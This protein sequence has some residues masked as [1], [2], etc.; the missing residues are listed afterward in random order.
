VFLLNKISDIAMP[1]ELLPQNVINFFGGIENSYNTKLSGM[2]KRLWSPRDM[3]WYIG[4]IAILYYKA[5]LYKP[6][7][8]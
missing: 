7:S 8:E 5:V 4:P 3:F 1:T 6:K 2:E